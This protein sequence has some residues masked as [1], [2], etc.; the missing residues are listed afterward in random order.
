MGQGDERWSFR[1]E[2]KNVSRGEIED[3]M[4]FCITVCLTFN[5]CKAEHS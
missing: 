2:D 5:Y 4:W 3:S 1:L